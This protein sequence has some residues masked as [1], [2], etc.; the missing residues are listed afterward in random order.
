VNRISVEEDGVEQINDDEELRSDGIRV[1]QNSDPGDSGDRVEVEAL[2]VSRCHVT[3]W[4]FPGGV[5]A[6]IGNHDF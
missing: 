1:E 4:R 3:R 5:T 6:W 2:L